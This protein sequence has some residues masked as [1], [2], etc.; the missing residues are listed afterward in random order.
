MKSIY[1]DFLNTGLTSVITVFGLLIHISLLNRFV[2]SNESSL[3][4]LLRRYT[5]FLEHFLTFGASIAII[6]Y[7]AKYKNHSFKFQILSS[8]IVITL[9]I[10]LSLL[11]IFLITN[12]IIRNYFYDY[13]FSFALIVIW[14]CYNLFYSIFII[15]YAWLRS[16]KIYKEANLLQLLII[17][18]FPIIVTFFLVQKHLALKYIFICVFLFF[19]L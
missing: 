9:V 19:L 10:N 2:E 18:V 8:L 12:F 7:I 11:I 1:K 15:Y 5:T 17:A 4:L 6:H 14:S 3:Y 16:Q 13:N